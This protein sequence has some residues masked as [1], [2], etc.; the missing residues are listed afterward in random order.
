MK[1]Q[2]WQNKSSGLVW[3]SEP[4][5]PTS[6]A[7][8]R[9]GKE[10]GSSRAVFLR[11]GSPVPKLPPPV[12]AT[13]INQED[14]TS[15]GRQGDIWNVYIKN[16][17]HR[18]CAQFESAV[19]NGSSEPQK[20]GAGLA[21]DNGQVWMFPFC[22]NTR[23]PSSESRARCA[24]LAQLTLSLG[25]ATHK[26]SW[27]QVERANSPG[28]TETNQRLPQEDAARDER[29]A[30]WPCPPTL[31]LSQFNR[32]ELTSVI[33]IS[34][35]GWGPGLLVLGFIPLLAGQ[36]SVSIMV[37]ESWSVLVALAT[38]QRGK[39]ERKG[40]H[41]CQQPLQSLPSLSSQ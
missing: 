16:D 39:E 6:N 30:P 3:A 24:T 22:L 12:T 40:K 29:N 26:G 1:D 14:S 15:L 28:G 20:R 7:S 21:S 8:G 38:D 34:V 32:W 13:T 10:R 17:T 37:A 18:G 19:V 36:V 41:K 2:K 11:Q 4:S 25:L 35:V 23:L 9:S 31:S 27:G 5:T 33:L